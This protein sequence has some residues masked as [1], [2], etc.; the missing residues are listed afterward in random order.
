MRYVIFKLEEHIFGLPM[1]WVRE[2][3]KSPVVTPIPQSPDCIAGV[4]YLRQHHVAVMDL[5]KRLGYPPHVGEYYVIMAKWEKKVL[6]LIVDKVLDI[7][8][9][10]EQEIDESRKV[11]TQY[12][13]AKMIH[14]ICLKEGKEIFLLSLENLLEEKVTSV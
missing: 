14:G 7:F 1:E 4:I 3:L 11:G 5:G 6:G 9:I 8:E 10:Q 2:I 13:N 12:L